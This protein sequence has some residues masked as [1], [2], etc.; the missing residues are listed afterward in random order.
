VGVTEA[1]HPHRAAAELTGSPHDLTRRPSRSS[2]GRP[3]C[4]LCPALN[5]SGE[6]CSPVAIERDETVQAR[7]GRRRRASTE[8]DILAATKRLLASGAPVASLTVER[9]VG[10]AGTARAT[11]YL[12]FRD[13]HDVISRLAAEEVA[14]RE[15]VGAEALADPGLERATLDRMLAEVVSRWMSDHAVLAAI[16]ELAEYDPRMRETWRSAMRQVTEKAAAQLQ[17]RWSGSDDA[18]AD[19]AT[20]AEIF[21]WMFERSC[22][23]ILADPSREQAVADSMSEIIWRVLDY[24]PPD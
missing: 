5:V 20:V 11:F 24:R 15:E 22:H 4:V 2:I 1:L 6:Y 7:T 13:K 16:I 21:T 19:P 12:H 18:P 9:I 3:F 14:W 10:E 17:A 23:Q 8:A